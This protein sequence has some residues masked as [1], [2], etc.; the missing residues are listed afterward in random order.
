MR[1]RDS[2]ATLESWTRLPKLPAWVSTESLKTGECEF[3]APS[4]V[5]AAMDA[6]SYT[7]IVGK[8]RRTIVIRSGGFAGVFQ[9]FEENESNQTPQLTQASGPRG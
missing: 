8:N 3:W 2:F 6:F 9:I 1:E 4:G 5:P 7:V